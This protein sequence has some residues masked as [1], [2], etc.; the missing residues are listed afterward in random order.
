MFVYANWERICRD[1]SERFHTIPACEILKQQQSVGWIVVKHDVETDVQK[2]VK[3]AEIEKKYNISATYYIQAD[4]LEENAALIKKIASLGHEIAYHYDVLDACD[5]NFDNAIE[6]FKDNLNTFHQLGFSIKTVCPHG[7]P[8]KIRNGWTSNKDFFR[9]RKVNELFPDMLDIVVHLPN[10]LKK[11]YL[12][13]SDAGYV[14][15][16]IANIH[17][18]DKSNLGDTVLEQNMIATL[19]PQACVILSTHPHRWESNK[20]QF[21]MKTMRFKLLRAIARRLSAI[22]AIKKI[23]S[24]YYYVAKKI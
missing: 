20:F 3:L 13:I 1:L 4:L 10:I 6:V 14:F 23:M 2:A 7:N 24:K 16:K 17:N 15:K 22:G 12:Y 19:D 21:I 9:E 8:I 11:N 5:G 18:N